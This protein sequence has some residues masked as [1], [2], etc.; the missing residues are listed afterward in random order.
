MRTLNASRCKSGE[1][2]S[3]LQEL[4]DID[5]E[6]H[7]QY[8]RMSKE[9][10][11][12]LLLRIEDQLIHHGKHRC[13][14]LPR[15]RLAVTLRYLAMGDSQQTIAISYRIGKSTVNKLMY[16]TC[17]VL[18]ESL[19]PDYV[20]FP[21]T[22][23]EWRTIARDFELFWNYPHC[24]GAIDSKHIVIKALKNSDS[25]YFNYKG[26]HSVVLLAVLD[27]RYRFIMMD[28]G[29][30]GQESDGGVLAKSEFGRRLNGGLL[31][32]P[33]AEPVASCEDAMPY[34]FVGDQA[35]PLKENMMR[36]YPGIY[37]TVSITFTRCST[38]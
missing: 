11:D 4:R 38:L 26:F 5:S 35:F 34:V 22:E 23:E 24:I 14:I 21:S 31:R 30:Y 12:E 7:H 13:P 9:Q 20:R 8:F 25:D 18:W 10:F 28:I 33:A 3:L 16:G 37:I 2:H 1:Y 15:E 29:A 19:Y 6:R 17:A 32:L 36:P 27:A